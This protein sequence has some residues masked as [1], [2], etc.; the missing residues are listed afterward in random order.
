MSDE[1]V[2]YLEAEVDS[3]H[4]QIDDLKDNVNSLQEALV[5]A[6][7][8]RDQL[9]YDLEG[10]VEAAREDGQTEI[11]E[12]QEKVDD[13]ERELLEVNGEL[14]EAQDEDFLVDAIAEDL[15]KALLPFAGP[16]VDASPIT[17]LTST[18]LERRGDTA[19]ALSD[20]VF[21]VSVAYGALLDW[22]KS[23]E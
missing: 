13:L 8:E 3:L 4:A 18:D 17:Y 21:D 19:L 1:A 15:K 2:A 10:E 5:A 16:C 14:E 22:L 11:D 23:R 20:F 6:E 9:R 12:L 7:E